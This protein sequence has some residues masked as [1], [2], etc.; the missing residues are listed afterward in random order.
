MAIAVRKVE[1]VWEGSLAAGTGTL[2]GSDSG[3]LDG[4][5]VTWDARTTEAGGKTSPE[6]LCAAA[7]ASCFSMALALKLGEAGGRPERLAVSAAV[8]LD[9]V[10][11]APTIVTSEITVKATVPDL[12]NDAFQAA[13]AGAAELCPVSRLFTGAKITV[14]GELA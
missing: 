9:E 1:S 13:L 6:E 11:G 14:A 3:V 12:D 5:N 8:T 2:G 7:H 10:D 4:Q